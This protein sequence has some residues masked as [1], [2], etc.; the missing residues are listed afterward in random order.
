M[1]IQNPKISV[2]MPIYNR[3]EFLEEAIQSILNQSY[4]D[5]E[6]IIINDGSTDNSKSVV[7][8]FEDN[9]IVYVENQKNIGV[10]A[11]ANKG[12]RLAKGE[13]IA[14]MDSDDI[15]LP[16]RLEAQLKF[17]EK[18]KEIALCG[19]W[20]RT[21]G[22]GKT[23][24]MRVPKDHDIIKCYML[25]SNVIWQPT[26]MVRKNILLDNNFYYNPEYVNGEDYD[27]WARILKRYKVANL[28][29]VLLC[30]RIHSNQTVKIF[31]KAQIENS[32]KIRL[33]QLKDIEI[34]SESENNLHNKICELDFKPSV[35]FLNKSIFWLKKMKESNDSKKIYNN[36]I[37]SDV[38]IE[39][40]FSVFLKSL[41]LPKVEL[42]KYFFYSIN[43]FLKLSFRRKF[44][45]VKDFLIVKV[46]KK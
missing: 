25:F 30:Y 7:S 23:C 4:V 21:F 18:N 29:K 43:M 26:I 22:E 17:L 32:G 40:W 10:S 41:T 31:N 14:R 45:I 3:R 28:E 11:S 13:Y 33:N 37:F 6:F 27:L 20:I 9:R 36:K 44:T 38:L 39:K 8:Q 12:I 5:F 2:V 35:Y 19:S 1:I 46:L 34:F 24:I 15:S 16:D 42:I